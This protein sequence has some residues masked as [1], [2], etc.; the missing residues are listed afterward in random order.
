MASRNILNINVVINSEVNKQQNKLQKKT[1][2]SLFD[3]DNSYPLKKNTETVNIHVYIF[4]NYAR[5]KGRDLTQSCDKNPYTHRT[6]QKA[7]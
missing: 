7:T 2:F 3:E 5:E 1:F 4:L 6:I